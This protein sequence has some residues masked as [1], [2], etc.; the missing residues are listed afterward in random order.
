M[1]CTSPI[2]PGNKTNIDPDKDL[3]FIATT[4]VSTTPVAQP[5]NALFS[6]PTNHTHCELYETVTELL[7]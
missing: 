5:V 6:R 7:V 3:T 1:V 2:M 4:A